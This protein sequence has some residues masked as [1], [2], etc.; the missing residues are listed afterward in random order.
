MRKWVVGEN[1]PLVSKLEA[2]NFRRLGSMGRLLVVRVD[3]VGMCGWGLVCGV[4][5]KGGGWW[6]RGIKGE[7]LG[8]GVCLISP[9]NC[10]P[11][12]RTHPERCR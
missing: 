5:G 10:R 6:V 9:K 4:G 3:V 2:H 11:N 7:G 8:G 12:I 1:H